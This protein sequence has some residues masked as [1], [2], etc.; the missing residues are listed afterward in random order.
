LS[1]DWVPERTD[2]IGLKNR[3]FLK[4]QTPHEKAEKRDNSVSSSLLA[5]KVPKNHSLV[6]VRDFPC[7]G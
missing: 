1:P 5:G 3:I 7:G 2:K 6:I 4:S